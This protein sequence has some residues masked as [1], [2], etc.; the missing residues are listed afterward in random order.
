MAGQVL[1]GVTDLGE[2]DAD[3]DHD[4][5]A[6]YRDLDSDG[7]GITDAVEAVANEKA[8]RAGGKDAGGK[9]DEK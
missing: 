8:R 1:A 7:D 9:K 6:N 3:N 4:Q 2:T 5:I